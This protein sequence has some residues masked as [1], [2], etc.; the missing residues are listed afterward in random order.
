MNEFPLYKDLNKTN[1]QNKE[2]LAAI[3]ISKQEKKKK[4]KRE[5]EKKKTQ[6]QNNF[7]GGYVCVSPFIH[8]NMSK[9]D[10]F[11][12]LLSERNEERAGI[13]VLIHLLPMCAVDNSA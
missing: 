11:D 5:K 3:V 2:I 1:K 6:I 12:F 4:K 9:I 8:V 10:G 13:F 7:M